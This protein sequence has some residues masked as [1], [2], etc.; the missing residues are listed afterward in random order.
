MR[1]CGFASASTFR[2]G[3]ESISSP[4]NLSHHCMQFGAFRATVRILFP[5]TS[6]RDNTYQ[7]NGPHQLIWCNRHSPESRCRQQPTRH[8]AMSPTSAGTRLS[9]RLTRSSLISP[10]AQRQQRAR[11]KKHQKSTPKSTFWEEMQLRITITFFIN[12]L[13]NQE[14]NI[15]YRFIINKEIDHQERVQS[16]LVEIEETER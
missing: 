6:T 13:E 4:T 1:S 15:A 5:A 12:R 16:T 11:R 7:G 9:S 8:R 10:V 2:P 3:T 14:R